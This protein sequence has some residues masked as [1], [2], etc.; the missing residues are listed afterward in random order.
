V[1]PPVVEECRAHLECTLEQVTQFGAEALVFGRV[2]AA[3]I[4]EACVRGSSE[5][6]YFRLRPLFFL[7]GGTYGSIDAAKHVGRPW[8]TDQQLFLV[9]IGPYRGG[10]VEA[11]VA[12]LQRL[13]GD[14]RLLV[15]GPYEHA[16]D[17]PSG[18]Y[19]LSAD[20]AAEAERLARSDPFVQA[21][22]SFTVRRWT[23]R[24]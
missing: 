19:V 17:E 15:A 22:A 1:S 16:D 23:R 11:H 21:G 8:P 3:A 13:R 14:G 24:F 9:E 2:V 5:E 4:D 10:S 20:S 18:M 12:F 6:Q 7:E